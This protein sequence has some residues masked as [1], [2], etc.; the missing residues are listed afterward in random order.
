[1]IQSRRNCVSY[2]I[3]NYRVLFFGLWDCTSIYPSHFHQWDKN[4]N[5]WISSGSAQIFTWTQVWTDFI[6][7]VKGQ[8]HHAFTYN[9]CGH[10]S[11]MYALMTQLNVN[12]SRTRWWHFISK[13]SLTSDVPQKHF[14]SLFKV[15]KKVTLTVFL[16]LTDIDLAQS[17]AHWPWKKEGVY[18]RKTETYHLIT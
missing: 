1:M 14:R 3:W 17:S 13:W 6:L 2:L 9:I 5:E 18:H 4:A 11:Q 12:I 7:V 15:V 10:N 8:G 16:E